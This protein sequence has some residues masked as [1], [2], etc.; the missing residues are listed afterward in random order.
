MHSGG[1]LPGTKKVP[2]VSARDLTPTIFC[3]KTNR[4][5]DTCL[6]GQDGPE[7]K[8]ERLSKDYGDM[9]IVLTFDE[10]WRRSEDAVKSEPVE[11]DEK[12]YIEALCVLP[13]VSWV[14]TPDAESFKISE[15]TMGAVT[16]IYVRLGSRFFTFSDTIRMKHEDCCAK[17]FHSQAYREPAHAHTEDVTPSEPEE[18]PFG[19]EWPSTER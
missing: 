10:A 8:L 2:H 5:I 12:A 18:T 17:V 19:K 15:R 6:P 16:S 9:L 3:T 14:I 7:D 1:N 4:I 11:I 13:P